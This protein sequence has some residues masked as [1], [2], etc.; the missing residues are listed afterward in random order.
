[1]P[2][3]ILLFVDILNETFYFY[4]AIKDILENDV[5]AKNCSSEISVI[6][7]QH[8]Y[9]LH[10]FLISLLVKTYMKIMK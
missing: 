3:S 2:T 1:M 5:Y 9:N 8:I 4:K 10:T 7:D 6:K